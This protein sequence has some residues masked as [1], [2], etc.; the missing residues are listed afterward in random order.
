MST[1]ETLALW[2]IQRA[3]EVVELAAAAGLP[4]AAAAALL[5]Q[6][7]GGGRNVW[8]GDKVKNP[9]VY[10]SG[11]EVTEAD[12]RAFRRALA[13][14]TAG[15]QGVG[16]VQLTGRDFQD[17]ADALGGCWLPRASTTVGFRLLAGYMRR[18]DL[19][20]AFRAYNGGAGTVLDPVKYPSPPAHIYEAK[21]M[22]KYARW[23]VRL[24]A[25]SAVAPAATPSPIPA[26][27]VVA[28]PTP[29]S[30][31][32]MSTIEIQRGADGS[33]RGVAVCE[34]GASSSLVARAWVVVGL[35]WGGTA[36][37]LVSFL[38]DRGLVLPPGKAPGQKRAQ[39]ANNRRLVADVP[40]GAVLVTVEGHASPGSV[41][42]GAV[43]AE[44]K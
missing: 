21:A 8:G 1:A 14:G 22:Q 38:D 13:A 29:R 2:G 19:A 35:A 6:E 9:G 5:E 7:S 11:A 30:D 44:P 3:D 31:D 15:Q 4:I 24:G 32:P 40:D 43:L 33:F 12:Y 16:P 37:V 17:Q 23:L 39:V 42:S 20:R 34:A 41:L 27:A 25:S 28:A 10:R 26:A 36:D 18:W